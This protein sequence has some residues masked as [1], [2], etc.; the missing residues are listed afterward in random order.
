MARGL[1]LGVWGRVWSK[2]FSKAGLCLDDGLRARR[3]SGTPSGFRWFRARHS[4]CRESHS[5][6]VSLCRSLPALTGSE[7][8]QSWFLN[9]PSS[10]CW[11][12]FLKK[13]QKTSGQATLARKNFNTL[14]FFFLSI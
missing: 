7:S 10:T 14:I 1:H 5:E 8:W 3:S 4:N 6:K 2:L 13:G 12:H 9:T 11:S